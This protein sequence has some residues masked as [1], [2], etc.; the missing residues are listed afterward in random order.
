EYVQTLAMQGGLKLDT[1][2]VERVVLFLNGQ[3]WGVYGMRERP[4]D[5]D[6]TK[7][8]YDQDKYNLHYL[9]T[10]GSTEAEYGGLAAFADWVS[11]RDFILQNDMGDPVNYE[12][13]KDQ[14]QMLSLIDYMVV[15]LNCVAS[16]WLNYNTGWWRGLDPEGDHKKWGY[17]LW[18]LDA[19]FD[20]YINYSGVPNTDPDAQPCDI[21]DISDYMDEFFNEAPIDVIPNPEE[22]PTILNGNSPYPVTDSIFIQVINADH[23]CCETEWDNICQDA[24]DAIS[25]NPGG[26]VNPQGNVGKH[27]KIFLKLQ[28]ESE[29]FR[30]LYFSRQA[31]LQNTVYTCENMLQTLDSMLAVIEPEMPRQIERWGGS[32]A[33]WEQNVQ[34]LIGFIEMRCEL[35]D[36]GMVDCYD[37]T[38]PY[39]LT[40]KVEPMGAGEI[41]LNTIDIEA[42]PWSG[43]YYGEMDNLIEAKPVDDEL[44]VFSHWESAAGNT[45]F[46]DV[47][48]PEAKIQLITQDTLTAVFTSLVKTDELDQGISFSVFPNPA[49]DQIVL[50]YELDEAMDIEVRL[51]SSIGEQLILP[52]LPSGKKTAGKHTQ[53]IG[54]KG[55]LPAGVYWLNFTS[56]EHRLTRKISV[57]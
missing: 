47:F 15:N 45:I 13:V 49:T 40:L 9:S 14:Y 6:Y 35:M 27:E 5:H 20:Y 11:L 2:A 1:R 3:Y 12:I 52:G 18:D 50:N 55:I 19:T 33:E 39:E 22:C 30:Q 23:Y 10:W 25:E 37:L 48:D 7:E 51:F 44:F 32:M 31:D 28:E 26:N 34:D 29:T 42:F 43:F 57:F 41:E 36:E 4:V 8:Y 54:L 56:G 46:P 16:D 53:I 38:G 17:I 24:Y 21:E